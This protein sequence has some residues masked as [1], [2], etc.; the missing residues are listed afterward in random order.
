MKM[1]IPPVFGW[2]HHFISS[3][4]SQRRVLLLAFAIAFYL[5]VLLIFRKYGI[6]REMLEPVLSPMQEYGAPVL[7]LLQFISSLT[8]L[9][10][11]FLIYA[12]V[13]IFG[14]A[15]TFFTIYA[16]YVSATCVSFAIARRFGKE[17]IFRRFPKM[18]EKIE[19]YDQKLKPHNLI[20]YRFFAF[21]AMD[22]LAYIAGFS[23]ISFR[24]Y[25]LASLITMP[26]LII[27]AIL[28]VQGLF[29]RNPLLF[30]LIYL[31]LACMMFFTS[32]IVK[33]LDKLMKK[34]E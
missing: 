18:I 14:P 27:P 34:V 11:N 24:S 20:V 26:F 1:K 3:R 4:I 21:S 8:P 25:L 9:P 28:L 19:S 32:Y 13:I 33:L 6:T 22:Y 10:D 5:I 16:S 31:C 29:E 23:N 17:R 12:G 30:G 15:K 7:Y 2:S